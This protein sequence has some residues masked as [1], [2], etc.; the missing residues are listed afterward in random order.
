SLKLGMLHDD[1]RLLQQTLR[2]VL[3]RFPSSPWD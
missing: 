1:S 2:R 3:G